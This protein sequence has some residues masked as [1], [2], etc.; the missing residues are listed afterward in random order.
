MTGT[1]TPRPSTRRT[2]VR[3]PKIPSSRSVILN[4]FKKFTLGI[5]EAPRLLEMVFRHGYTAAK[6]FP[7]YQGVAQHMK[8]LSL[9]RSLYSKPFSA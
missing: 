8:E 9:F 3:A 4:V 7:G 5:E 2:C 1:V 6:L